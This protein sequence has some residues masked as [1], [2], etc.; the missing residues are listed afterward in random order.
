MTAKLGG[1]VTVPRTQPELP[2]DTVLGVAKMRIRTAAETLAG[3]LGQIRNPMHV[4]PTDTAV[5]IL[6]STRTEMHGARVAFAKLKHHFPKWSD[7]KPSDETAALHILH[8]LGFAN[9]RW[10]NLLALILST[11]GAIKPPNP[12]ESIE[13]VLYGLMNI[14][15]VGPKT[16]RC[17]MLYAWH[18]PVCPAD[19]HGVRFVNRYLMLSSPM[20]PTLVMEVIDD[21]LK[22]T[23]LHYSF[24][25]N[26]ITIGRRYCVPK[27]PKCDECPLRAGC[28]H[29]RSTR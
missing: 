9:S 22:G 19:A 21:A 16:A 24:H 23:R 5:Q 8:P 26:M 1:G 27:N 10:G 20:S 4:D 7:V 3:E 13:S 29:G 25:M 15:G 28:A 17:V 6:L 11:K 2:M 12:S 18:M 14:P